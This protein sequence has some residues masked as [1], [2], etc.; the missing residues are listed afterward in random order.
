MKHDF[1]EKNIFKKHDSEEKN[2]FKKLILK[3]ALHTENHVLI[4]FT[5]YNVLVLRSRCN[6]KKHELKNFYFLKSMILNVNFFLK[7]IILNEKFL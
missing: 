5:P 1:E 3:K 4:Q 2:N 6:F 7:G